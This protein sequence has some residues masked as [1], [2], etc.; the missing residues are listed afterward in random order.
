MLSSL[1]LSVARSGSCTPMLGAVAAVATHIR[2]WLATRFRRSY[3]AQAMMACVDS[4]SDAEVDRPVR[5]ASGSIL[6]GLEQPAPIP[7]VQGRIHSIDTF[8]AVDGPGLRMVVFEQVRCYAHA[9]TCRYIIDKA[10]IS[11]TYRAL[12]RA[13]QLFP[14]CFS[15]ALS[16]LLCCCCAGMCH[17]LC[18][19]FQP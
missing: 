7:A 15:G 2:P 9:G 14:G 5:P 4:E 11:H 8:S 16:M 10:Y 19:L 1:A 13:R 12:Y 17:A 3:A 6:A 18:V